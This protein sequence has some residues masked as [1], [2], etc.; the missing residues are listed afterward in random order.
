VN[1]EIEHAWLALRGAV[2]TV[3]IMLRVALRSPDDRSESVRVARVVRQLHADAITQLGEV[4]AE[5]LFGATLQYVRDRLIAV[6]GAAAWEEA[7]LP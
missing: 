1:S 7:E 3:P 2:L 6:Y 5:D 4:E